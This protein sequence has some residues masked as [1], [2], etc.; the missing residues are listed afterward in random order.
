[1]EA[2]EKAE[3]S[4]AEK[5]NKSDKSARVNTLVFFLFCECWTFRF[6]SSLGCAPF[7]L[8]VYFHCLASSTSLDLFHHFVVHFFFLLFVLLGYLIFFASS[9]NSFICI[10]SLICVSALLDY[11]VCLISQCLH[12]HWQLFLQMKQLTAFPHILVWFCYVHRL[13]LRNT[14]TIQCR[15][16]NTELSGP[17][18]SF[19]AIS[20]SCNQKPYTVNLGPPRRRFLLPMR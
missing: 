5:V 8:L 11:G 19:G 10:L 15:S 12:S 9:S 16:L 14:T 7:I 18:Q 20:F 2:L 13:L 6:V 1:M 17:W 3:K 4:A